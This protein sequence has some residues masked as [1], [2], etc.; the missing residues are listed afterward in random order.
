M[1]LV[2]VEGTKALKAMFSTPRRAGSR[3]AAARAESRMLHEVGQL[4]GPL[5]LSN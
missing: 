3:R 2:M 1:V 4:W 5:G